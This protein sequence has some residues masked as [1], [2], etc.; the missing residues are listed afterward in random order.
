MAPFSF[1]TIGFISLGTT[2]CR[3]YSQWE[4][5]KRIITAKKNYQNKY[6]FLFLYTINNLIQV[7][8]ILKTSILS[9]IFFNLQYEI[10]K[11]Y[12]YLLIINP[13]LACFLL[14]IKIKFLERISPLAFAT[15]LFCE[16]EKMKQ[17]VSREQFYVCFLN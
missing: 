13:Q 3:I 10:G 16:E 9:Q 17:K 5:A 1:W 12:M 6:I 15:A 7:R 2:L 11:I 4:F 14:F 8:Y